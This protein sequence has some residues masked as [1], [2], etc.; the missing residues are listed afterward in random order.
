MAVTEAVI[1]CGG[2]GTRLRSVVSD[3]PKCMAEV[4]GRPFLEWV[5]DYLR[6]QGITR[7]VFCTGYMGR[8]IYK[9]FGWGWSEGVQFDY[10]IDEELLGTAGALRHALPE[11]Q[12]SPFLVLN[13]DTYCR[14]DI[15]HLEREH[16]KKGNTL[17]TVLFY[18]DVSAGVYLMDREV[19]ESIPAGRPVSLEKEIFPNISDQSR[20]RVVFLEFPFLDIGTPDRYAAAE[21]FLCST[22]TEGK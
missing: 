7:T 17:A 9:H 2:L 10:S 21:K 3:R 20:V 8:E 19:I 22:C 6:E 15:E 5:V 14:F 18:H 16:S 1:L 4:A 11:I 13:G 12:S